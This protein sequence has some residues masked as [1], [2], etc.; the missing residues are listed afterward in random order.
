[1]GL[2]SR[3]LIRTTAAGTLAGL[4]T[5]SG[6]VFGPLSQSAQGDRL[7]ATASVNLRSG[8][9]L[10]YPVVGGLTSGQLI[11]ALDDS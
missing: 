6:M 10:D 4:M 5:V 2:F 8:P 3:A 7:T 11:T 9:G 1:M